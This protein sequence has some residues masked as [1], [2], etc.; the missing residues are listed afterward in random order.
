MNLD[1]YKIVD[2]ITGCWR[3]QGVKLTKGYAVIFFNEKQRRIHR[4]SAH[5][6]LGLDLDSDLLSLHKTECPYRD[7][8]N[9]DHL[10]IGTAQN[11]AHDRSIVGHTQGW[12]WQA[13][14]THC[15]RGH[16]FTAENTFEHQGRRRCR[17]CDRMRGRKEI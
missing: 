16:E 7:C 12:K 8:F 4:V 5:L 13:N 11:N 3:T 6:Y 15:S 9:P 17:E 1:K 10:Y 14:K 2:E